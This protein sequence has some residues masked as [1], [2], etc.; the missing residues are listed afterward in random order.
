MPRYIDDGMTKVA[1]ATVADPAFVAL[2]ELAA[3]T[4]IECDITGDG[5]NI[6]FNE[7]S[8][9]DSA[10]CEPFDAV[11]P[12]SFG[13]TTELTLKRR[14]KEGGDT[15]AMWLLFNTRNEVGALVVRRGI[16]S[17]TAWAAGQDV[18]VYP[19]RVG[20][21]RPRAT[22]RNQQTAFMVTFFGSE[23]PEMDGIVVA[24]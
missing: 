4:D 2:S 9:D 18:E 22:A 1:W 15:D 7:N 10:L 6:T 17:D 13:V 16:D 11:L 23:E 21:R 5:L 19:S 8:V 14:N 12:G 3:G 24:S 20:Q